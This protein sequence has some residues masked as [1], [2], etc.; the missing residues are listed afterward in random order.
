MIFRRHLAALLPSLVLGGL[1]SSVRAAEAAEPGS[2]FDSLPVGATIYQQVVV[3]SVTT[4][5]VVI[6]HTGGLASI[7]LHDLSPEWQA[8]FHYDP[9][10]E[11]AADQAAKNA[12]PPI[13]K[14]LA[15]TAATFESGIDKLFQQFG[16]PANLQTEVNLHT[17]FAEY[18]L[19]VRNQGRRPSCAI[20]AIVCALE[21]ENARLTGQGQNFSED[22]LIWATRKTVHRIP[23][24][25]APESADDADAG[26]ILTEVV[27][28]LRAYGIPL[29]T[30]MPNNIDRKIEAIEDPPA[31][32]I[33]EARAHERVFAH[34][35][36]GRDTAT[37]INNIVHA[38]NAGKPVAVGMAW[39]NYHSLRT[40]RLS[41]QRPMTGSGHAVTLVGY[42]SPTGRIEDAV[43]IFKNSWGADWGQGGYG[44]ATYGYLSANLNDAVLLEVQPG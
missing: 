25:S 7:R 8:R 24:E 14:R 13:A 16:Q 41:A 10:A 28:A 30:S 22:Y 37:R 17:K 6:T 42:K 2:R 23:L 3:R 35:L 39:P 38:L 27:T 33:K 26:F 11:A 20:Y 36:P 32:I 1:L 19:G 29:Q 43:F 12:P 18:G 34:L 5:T 44:T 21:F 15:R 4:R 40:G 9:A 31:E